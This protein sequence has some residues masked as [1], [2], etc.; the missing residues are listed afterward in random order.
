MRVDPIHINFVNEAPVHS[1]P[2]RATAADSKII[3]T[4]IGD[5]VSKGLALP[6]DG[7]FSSPVCLIKQKGKHRLVVDYCNVNKSVKIA[8]KAYLLTIQ[9]QLQK[10]PRG[11]ILSSVD[12]VPTF[13]QFGIDDKTS[14]CLAM[15]MERGPFRPTHLPF[16]L[17][18]SPSE[19]CTQM[20][21]LMTGF[22]TDNLIQYMDDLVIFSTNLDKLIELIGD[23]LKCFCDYGLKINPEKSSLFSTRAR[24]LGRDMM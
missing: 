10:I 13:W 24:V 17:V 12:L 11:A 20:Q 18:S 3:N 4:L 14:Q 2:Y 8:N 7:R 21:K 5:M 15:A 19:M 23:L 16:G 9:S 6:A 1:M 22:P